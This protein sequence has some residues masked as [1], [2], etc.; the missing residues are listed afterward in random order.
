MPIVPSRYGRREMHPVVLLH[1]T[2]VEA[3]IGTSPL[4]VLPPTRG[5]ETA[6]FGERVV[7]GLTE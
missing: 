2:P 3:V 6:R 4:A 7:A 5:V 1:P